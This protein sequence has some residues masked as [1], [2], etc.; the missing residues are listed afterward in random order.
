MYSTSLGS[1]T[2]PRMQLRSRGLPRSIAS[3]IFVF[4]RSSTVFSGFAHLLLWTNEQDNIL[5]GGKPATSGF[6]DFAVVRD[7][8]GTGT[9]GSTSSLRQTGRIVSALTPIW[10]R[11]CTDLNS[12]CYNLPTVHGQMRWVV[13]S[14]NRIWALASCPF[15]VH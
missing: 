9:S 5:R 15:P 14:C 8:E 11:A 1:A 6:P 2:R 3:G 10:V 12:V 7:R 4:P 13:G